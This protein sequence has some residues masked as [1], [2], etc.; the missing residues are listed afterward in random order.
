MNEF[1]VACEQGDPSVGVVAARPILQ[2][3]FYGVAD[4]GELRAY[5]VLAPC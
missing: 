1:D 4:V 5:L 2:V 3:S